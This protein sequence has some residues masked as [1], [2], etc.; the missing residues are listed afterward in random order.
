MVSHTHLS[1]HEIAAQASA[2]IHVYIFGQ[3]II[4]GV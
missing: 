4:K 1:M 3:W 2:F